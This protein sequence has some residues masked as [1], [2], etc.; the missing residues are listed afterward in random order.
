MWLLLIYSAIAAAFLALAGRL[1]DPRA[2]TSGWPLLVGAL[3]AYSISLMAQL[4]VVLDHARPDSY[5]ATVQRLHASHSRSSTT[6]YADLSPWGPDRSEQGDMAVSYAFYGTLA[7]GQTLCVRL[8]PGWLRV[9]W[10]R[11][12]RCGA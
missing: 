8:H 6:Y 5:R 4:D 1:T 2:G 3:L 9:R 12:E 10:Y 7:V 11:L